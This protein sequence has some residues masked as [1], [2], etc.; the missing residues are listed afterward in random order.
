VRDFRHTVIPFPGISNN[1]FSA[2]L[3]LRAAKDASR[4]ATIKEYAKD[5]GVARSRIIEW[6]ETSPKYRNW[7]QQML[8]KVEP[9]SYQAA[10]T[11][12]LLKAGY[13]RNGTAGRY[14]KWHLPPRDNDDD[15]DDDND[16][17]DENDENDE[18]DDNDEPEE[19]SSVQEEQPD[20]SRQEEEEEEEEEEDNGDNEGGEQ[21]EE[22]GD[23]DDNV[24]KEEEEEEMQG[25]EE[26]DSSGEEENGT[27]EQTVDNNS[28][29]DED[30]EVDMTEDKTNDDMVV[31]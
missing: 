9:R 16:D 27:L 6:I 3:V 12:S 28:K 18:N 29:K 2:L 15:D 10:I 7:V 25:E 23:D 31:E 19:E 5:N 13:T 14:V 4:S 26:E 22:D 11:K 30:Q 17:N 8:S 1:S 20:E 21:E 24:V